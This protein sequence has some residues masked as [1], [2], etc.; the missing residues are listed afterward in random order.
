MHRSRA[1]P[2]GA[3]TTLAVL[4]AGCGGGD[5]GG[6]TSP[7]PGGFPAA[8]AVTAAATNSF[9]PRTVDIVAGGN[10]TWM[11]NAIHNVRFGATAGAPQDIPDTGDGQVARQFVAA[12]RFPYNCTLHPGMSGTV[13]VH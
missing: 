5:G 8:A 2:L 12:G 4:L 7:P 6:T 11:F 1:A 9:S 10:V 13:V 3:L